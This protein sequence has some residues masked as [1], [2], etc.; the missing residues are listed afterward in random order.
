MLSF[1]L[2][3]FVPSLACDVLAIGHTQCSALLLSGDVIVFSLLYNAESTIYGV[4][5][6]EPCGSWNRI[7]R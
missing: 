7:A 6:D 5:T 3:A 2:P 1:S 4:A